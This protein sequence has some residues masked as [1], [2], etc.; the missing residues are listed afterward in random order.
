MLA[1]LD[2]GVGFACLQYI[3][4]IFKRA[5]FSTECNIIALIYINRAISL[6]SIPIHGRNWKMVVLVALILA[7]KV[8]DDSW[9]VVVASLQQQPHPSHTN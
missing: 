3:E 9:Y 7:Q 1:E 8:W 4:G 6:S 5:Q 2:G